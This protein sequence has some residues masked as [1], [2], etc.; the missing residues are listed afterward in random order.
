MV[1]SSLVFLFAFLPLVLAVYYIF[2]LKWRNHVLLF[3][4]LLFYAWGE[5][6][7]VLLLILSIT[8]N[9]L[10]GLALGKDLRP[11]NRKLTITCAIVFNISLL[12]HFKYAGFL[13]SNINALFG[14]QLPLESFVPDH[15]P[16][17][18][19]FFT[20]QAL[21]YIID[22]FRTP[23]TV[24]ASP[25]RLGLYISSFPQ[26]IAGPIV[27][28]NDVARQLQSR[29][30]S[31]G[32]FASG[33][34]RFIF[35]LGKKVLIANPMGEMADHIFAVPVAE[36]SMPE[37][38][39]GILCY[40][41][42]IYFDFSGYSD[43]AIGLGRM[44]GLSF[45]E[46]FNY[47][48]ISRSIQEFWRRWHISL[49]SWFRDY[50]Y[51]PL[52]GNRKGRVRTYGNLLLV[53]ALCGFW[54]G[55]SWNFLV[56]GLIHGLFLILE[57]AGMA[58]LLAALPN[59]CRHCYVLLVVLI[60]WV[61]FRA[62]N[63][64]EALLYLQKMFIYS[65]DGVLHPWI[66]NKVDAQVLVILLVGFLLSTPLYPTIRKS[67]STLDFTAGFP[68]IVRGGADTVYLVNLLLV[69]AM[70]ILALASGAY[71]PFIYFRF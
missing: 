7:Y 70:S 67:L 2:P 48:Y 41:L 68:A 60:G 65:S 49:S 11:W 22:C 10:F 31:F 61:F 26:L 54:H 32:L 19:S 28:Y 58:R 14:F 66:I 13:L 5:M 29:V 50:L 20:F 63:L 71:N 30:H 55:A 57:R 52:G 39:I 47:P 21:S 16:I 53:F 25:V 37:A 9:Y 18:I 24:Q 35:G 12:F 56:W 36:L 64:H 59:V 43:M 33:V 40:S 46:N 17:G 62:D 23:A 34:E 27:R 3:A 51:I 4:S 15:L 44:F 8:V 6:G 38:W 42:Q 69:F 45:L 1:F